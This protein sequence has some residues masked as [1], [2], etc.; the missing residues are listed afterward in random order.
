MVKRL[1]RA[2]HRF[3]DQDDTA[4]FQALRVRASFASLR[5]AVQI[6][7]YTSPLLCGYLL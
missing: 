4:Y 1:L 7:R 3:L 2:A 6:A 5:Q